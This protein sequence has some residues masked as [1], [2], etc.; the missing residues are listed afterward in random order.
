MNDVRLFTH[1]VWPS[2]V[3]GISVIMGSSTLS[4]IDSEKQTVS[5][6]VRE[7]ISEIDG[8]RGFLR[9]CRAV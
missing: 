9:A 8:V 7:T 5:L 3:G 1:V 2:L 4:K 6:F